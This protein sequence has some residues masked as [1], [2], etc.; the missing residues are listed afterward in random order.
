ELLREHLSDLS[1]RERAVRLD[2]LPERADLAGD[3]DVLALRG[4]ASERD[5]GAV[6]LLEGLG[7]VVFRQLDAVRVPRVRGEERRAR[8]HVVLVHLA[9]ELGRGEAERRAWAVRRRASLDEERPQ[10]AVG[11]QDVVQELLAD[12]PR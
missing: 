1:G 6:D 3:V 9:D 4:L 11:D 10:G 2:E 12:V 7:P 8:G 5:G